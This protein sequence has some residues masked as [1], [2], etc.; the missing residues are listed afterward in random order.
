MNAKTILHNLTHRV[1]VYKFGG[2]IE[3]VRKQIGFSEYGF[4][5]TVK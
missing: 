4:D 2:K 3:L 5:E 1:W